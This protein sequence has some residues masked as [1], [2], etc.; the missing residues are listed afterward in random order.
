MRTLLLALLLSLPLHAQ[1]TVARWSLSGGLGLGSIGSRA[2][3][4]MGGILTLSHQSPIGTISLRNAGMSGISFH[5]SYVPSAYDVGLLIG[6]TI[7]GRASVLTASA[8]LSLVMSRRWMEGRFDHQPT[9][10][11]PFEVQL[12]FPASGL[13][14]GFS[15]YGNLNLEST[16]Y[17]IGMVVRAEG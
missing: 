16:F 6:H 9:V 17:G 12:A 2:S 14:I 5:S 11:V 8:G 7:R 15:F 4:G 10:G 1:D 3:T 13:G